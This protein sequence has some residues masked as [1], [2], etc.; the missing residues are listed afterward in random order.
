M[1]CV[2]CIATAAAAGAGTMAFFRLVDMVRDGGV[3]K[4]VAFLRGSAQ[5]RG[6]AESDDEN[7]V[8]ST[9]DGVLSGDR[10]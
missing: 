6:G 8:A 4:T 3:R 9:G 1:V 2:S 10:S 7:G 5:V